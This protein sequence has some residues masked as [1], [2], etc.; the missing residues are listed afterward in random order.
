MREVGGLY[1]IIARLAGGA[2]ARGLARAS[3][4][5]IKKPDEGLGLAS[6]GNPPLIR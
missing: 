5:Q 1:R 3:L 2:A 6:T 4:P